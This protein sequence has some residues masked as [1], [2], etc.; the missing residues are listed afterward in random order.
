MGV[1]W[2]SRGCLSLRM[3]LVGEE[4]GLLDLAQGEE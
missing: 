4:D 3:C 2:G 1:V